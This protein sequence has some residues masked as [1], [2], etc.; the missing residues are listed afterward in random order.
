[1]V[2]ATLAFLGAFG[3]D[4]GLLTYYADVSGPGLP[5]FLCRYPERWQGGL[6]QPMTTLSRYKF[7]RYPKL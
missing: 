7:P 2:F 5:Y 1:M 3:A 6:R 4:Q